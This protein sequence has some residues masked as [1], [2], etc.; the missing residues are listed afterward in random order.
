M[1]NQL[2]AALAA[3]AMGGCVGTLEPTPPGNGSNPGGP[4]AG[5]HTGGNAKALFDST[6]YSII[7]AKCSSCH[8]SS[9]PVGNVTGFVASDASQGYATITGYTAVVGN[10]TTTSAGILGMPAS[11]TSPHSPTM[12]TQDNINAITAWLNQEAADRSG[13]NVTP[14]SPDAGSNETPS[15]ATQRLLLQWSGCMSQTN[16]DT[17]NMP[18]AWGQ[19]TAQNDQKCEDCH[20]N[21]AEGFI[22]TDQEPTFFNVVSTNK[23]YMLQYFTVD[24][25]QGVANAKVIVNTTS[26][27]GV[28]NGQPPHLEHPKFNPTGSQGMNALNQFYTLTTQRMAAGQCDPPRLTN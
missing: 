1:R 19:M 3:M 2:L 5:T 27:A 24:L 18:T 11:G 8:S 16:F 28:S 20:V 21:G 12:Y 4:D 17:A 15:Q 23:Y 26:F 7:Q 13:S 25:T 14:G 6:V 22:A 10:F 9:G